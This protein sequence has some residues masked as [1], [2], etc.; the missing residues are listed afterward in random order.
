[1]FL[2]VYR[3]SLLRPLSEIQEIAH[4]E[5]RFVSLARTVVPTILTG[6]DL[7]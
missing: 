3:S 2:F 6:L 5:Y 4:G 1:M 7:W